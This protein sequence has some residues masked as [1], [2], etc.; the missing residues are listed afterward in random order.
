MKA[1]IP[2][3]RRRYMAETETLI[4]TWA[5]RLIEIE[6]GTHPTRYKTQMGQL[7]TEI[8][9]YALD[10]HVDYITLYSAVWDHAEPELNPDI[11]GGPH[12]S[13]SW[14]ENQADE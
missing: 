11:Y 2:P 4:R 14:K 12:D 3:R 9:K 6:F 5:R 8:K 13:T 1:S 10:H 7:V